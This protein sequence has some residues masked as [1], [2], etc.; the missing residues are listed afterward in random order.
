MTQAQISSARPA[1]TADLMARTGLDDA[2]LSRLVHRFYDRV[3][4]DPMLGPIF[5]ERITD[6]GPHLAKM[7]DFWSSVALMTG[8]YHGAPM[9]KHLPLPV[10]AEHF[11]RWLTL[12]RATAAEVCPPAGAAWV[13]ERAERIASSIHMNI[14]DARGNYGRSG[15]PPKL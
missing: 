1:V 10:E 9:P 3:R 14:L 12:F 13:V 11:D 5:A 7:V 15:L 8:R 4:V 2:M 6:W